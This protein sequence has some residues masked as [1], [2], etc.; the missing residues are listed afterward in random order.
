MALRA[1]TDNDRFDGD[2]DSGEFGGGTTPPRAGGRGGLGGF[3]GFG[4]AGAVLGRASR[5]LGIAF[6]VVG[7]A[8]SVY[9]NVLARG[10][11]V[12]FPVDTAIQLQLA[13]APV[14]PVP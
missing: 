12:S 4:L 14:A 9:R 7:A 6:S 13:P 10:K 2:R 8:R 5:P 11:E 3:F 1:S